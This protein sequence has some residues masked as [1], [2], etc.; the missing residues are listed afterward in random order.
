MH[1]NPETIYLKR[2]HPMTMRLIQCSSSPEAT[3]E[4]TAMY[5]RRNGGGGGTKR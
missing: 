2:I 4:V 5:A 3:R 1:L